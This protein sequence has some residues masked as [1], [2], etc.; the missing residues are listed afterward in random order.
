MGLI[1]IGCEDLYRS[2][3]DRMADICE[4]GNETGGKE[5]SWVLRN[6]QLLKKDSAEDG[7]LLKCCIV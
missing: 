4:H 6:Y 5:I 7:C 1:G 3:Q 2:R